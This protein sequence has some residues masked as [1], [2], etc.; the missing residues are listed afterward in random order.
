MRGSTFRQ[1]RQA[2]GLSLTQVARKFGTHKQNIYSFEVG[3]AKN[4]QAW[5]PEVASAWLKQRAQEKLTAREAGA[6]RP[7]GRL[8]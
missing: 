3:L 1:Y 2:L 5:S 8:T 4:P 6:Q 7:G